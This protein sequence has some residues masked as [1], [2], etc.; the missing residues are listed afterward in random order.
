M[1]FFLFLLIF[2]FPVSH[3]TVKIEEG[4]DRERWGTFSA[5]TAS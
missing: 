1:L 2:Y 4:M 3:K 5:Q